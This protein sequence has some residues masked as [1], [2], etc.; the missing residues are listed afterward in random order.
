VQHFEAER[1]PPDRQ[2]APRQLLAEGRVE[3]SDRGEAPGLKGEPAAETYEAIRIRLRH[4]IS[5][6]ATI[7]MSINR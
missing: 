7:M 5:T 2:A 6:R 3:I 4:G 1:G